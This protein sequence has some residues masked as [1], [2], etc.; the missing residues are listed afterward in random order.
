VLVLD[1]DAVLVLGLLVLVLV[2]VALDQQGEVDVIAVLDAVTKLVEI[3]LLDDAV[4]ASDDLTALLLRGK[5]V[6][7]RSEVHL[8]V[9]EA[10][11]RVQDRLA[12]DLL[13]GVVA[14]LLCLAAKPLSGGK[15][16]GQLTHL[17]F[18]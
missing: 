13:A 16:L 10:H 3:V 4:E 6:L 14:L 11:D 15:K 7:D 18:L 1:L 17:A 12:L 9:E 5:D 2:L 8:A